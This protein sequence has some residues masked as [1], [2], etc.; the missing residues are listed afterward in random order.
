MGVASGGGTAYPSGES[1]FTFYASQF[2]F[3]T[4][5]ASEITYTFLYYL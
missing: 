5:A 3:A 2:C 4:M 1:E